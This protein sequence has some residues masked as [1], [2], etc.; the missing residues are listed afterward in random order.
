MKKQLFILLLGAGTLF[1]AMIPSDFF[2]EQL[3]FAR[4]RT[5][6]KNKGNAVAKLLADNQVN[7]KNF[8]LFIRAFKTEKK[9]EVWAKSQSDNTFKKITEYDFCASS[10]VLGPKR[11]SGDKQIPEGAYT[12]NFFNPTSQYH[13]SF[14]INYPNK[15][16]LA[17]ADALNPG[18]NIFIHG[19][20]VTIGCIPIGNE[21]ME[22]LYLLAAKAKS[23]GRDINVHIFPNKMD[24]AGMNALG[25]SHEAFW[26]MLQPIYQS[27]EN[28]KKLPNV[29]V[30]TK[31]NYVVN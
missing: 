29:S 12:V 7:D 13:L 3:S 21:N 2:R 1:T 18:D 26:K 19:D 31:G 22:E 25:N 27:F 8:D 14:R 15:S 16:D 28:T 9:L 20:C 23:A 30:D 6:N 17:F 10:G 11:K 24:A 5:A 4:V